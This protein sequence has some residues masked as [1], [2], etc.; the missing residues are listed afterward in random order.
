MMFDTV[1][2]H[3]NKNT[4]SQLKQY[5]STI[6]S[7]GYRTFLQIGE[8][9]FTSS[10][11][12]ARLKQYQILPQLLTEII[13][14]REIDKINCTEQAVTSAYQRFMTRHRLSDRQELLTWASQN[15]LSTE[16]LESMILR[17]VKIAKFKQANWGDRVEKYF[18]QHK[19]QLDSVLYS[20]IVVDTPE[21]IQ[22]LY[23]R[24]Q[25]GEQTFAELA[26]KYSQS[27]E[28]K[29]NG[30]IGP[31]PI[32]SLQTTIAQ[33]LLTSRVGELQ[34]PMRIGKLYVMLRLEKFISAE[35]DNSMRHSIMNDFF[36][37][38]LA[39]ERKQLAVTVR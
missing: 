21:I 31:V 26:S 2:P 17:P 8:Q 10:E 15:D 1:I 16:E 6:E 36:E 22:E 18:H 14:D 29:T 19:K 20:Q 9:I 3:T 30:L 7:E 39:Q 38:W 27:S 35:L 23:F 33:T 34:Y 13:I 11:I 12:L 25:E 24:L 28:A 32:Y 5:S 4:E 37:Q